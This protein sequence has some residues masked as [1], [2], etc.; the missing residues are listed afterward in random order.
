[1][2]KFVASKA[3]RN[4]RCWLLRQIATLRSTALRRSFVAAGADCKFVVAG[5]DCN[6]DVAAAHCSI[7]ASLSSSSPLEPVG[8]R[9][10]GYRVHQTHP[11]SLACPPS[12][13]RRTP[14]QTHSTSS[15]NFL[16]PYFNYTTVQDFYKK[17]FNMFADYK[18]VRTTPKHQNF[19]CHFE[20]Y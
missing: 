8:L 14:P 3:I 15:N 2:T 1:M 17:F 20:Q 16:Q 11:T 12:H 13:R 4:H 9:S 6:F 10:P 5:A 19:R 7:K 18:M